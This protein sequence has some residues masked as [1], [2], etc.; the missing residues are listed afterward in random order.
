MYT[1]NKIISARKQGY[2]PI[3]IH[4]NKGSRIFVEELRPF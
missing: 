3:V 4:E 1:R 2:T